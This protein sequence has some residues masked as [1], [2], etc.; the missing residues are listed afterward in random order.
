MN[1]SSL[2]G[3]KDGYGELSN[4]DTVTQTQKLFKPRSF[5]M[6]KL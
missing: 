5:G 3:Q 1:A 6:N 2:L 4:F